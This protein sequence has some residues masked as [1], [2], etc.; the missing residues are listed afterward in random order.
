M[1]SV[2]VKVTVTVEFRFSME[3]G[4]YILT[5]RQIQ[6]LGS[7]ISQ[8]DMET[9]ARGYLNYNDATIKNMKKGKTPEAFNREVLDHWKNKNPKNQVTV[10]DNFG[11]ILV[12]IV[13]YIIM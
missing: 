1:T 8:D 9:F 4:D 3:A 6:R 13:I 10:G 7:V 12:F 5:N 2:P 11:I